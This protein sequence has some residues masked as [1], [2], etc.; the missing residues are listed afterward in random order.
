ML[1]NNDVACTQALT[2][3]QQCNLNCLAEPACYQTCRSVCEM[4]EPGFLDAVDTLA[5]WCAGA[6]MDDCSAYTT[7]DCLAF[8]P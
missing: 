4:N 2:C 5:C 3:L 8:A 6:C 1:C 7:T